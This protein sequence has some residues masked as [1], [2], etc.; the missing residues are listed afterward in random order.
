MEGPWPITTSRRNHPFTLSSGFVVASSSLPSW[1]WLANTTRTR[2]FAASMHSIFFRFVFYC[3][4]WDNNLAPFASRVEK[5]LFLFPILMSIYT[6]STVIVTHSW[7]SLLV[8]SSCV[9][10]ILFWLGNIL[11]I[12]TCFYLCT[13]VCWFWSIRCYARLHPR[14]VNCR[15][16]KCGHSNQ[17]RPQLMLDFVFFSST[18]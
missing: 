8:H 10:W 5:G 12:I 1:L 16:K 17:V 15:K 4:L 9:L 2:W 6:L 14:A 13:E 3:V 7:F 11:L 18:V